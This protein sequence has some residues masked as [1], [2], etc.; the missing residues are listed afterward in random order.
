MCVC[1]GDP[2]CCDKEWDADCVSVAGS[3]CAAV[4]GCDGPAAGGCGEHY[5]DVDGSLSVNVVDVQCLIVTTLSAL[6]GAPTEAPDCLAG[7]VLS[8]DLSCDS[9]ITVVDVQLV[10]QLTLGSGLDP[11]I[12]V[13]S[14]SCPDACEQ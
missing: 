10:I 6:G 8:A 3:L 1:S 14:N 2:Y 11:M 4:C 5:G 9:A 7:S 12:D 13:D